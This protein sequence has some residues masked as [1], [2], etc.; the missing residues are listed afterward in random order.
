MSQPPGYVM[1]IKRCFPLPREE[2]HL[3]LV[4]E[5]SLSIAEAAS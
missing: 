1:R 3:D 5:S 2:T 4:M